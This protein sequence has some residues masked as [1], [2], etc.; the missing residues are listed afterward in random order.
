[1][2]MKQRGTSHPSLQQEHPSEEPVQSPKT[3]TA[4]GSCQQTSINMLQEQDNIQ[5][6]VIEEAYSQP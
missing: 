4:S 5:V 3:L 1:M 2:K 6:D